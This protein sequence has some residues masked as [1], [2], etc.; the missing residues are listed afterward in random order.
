MMNTTEFEH[1]AS[2]ALADA[3]PGC[4][5]GCLGKVTVIS[6]EVKAR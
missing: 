5:H 2:A 1:A 3:G 6:C 4:W